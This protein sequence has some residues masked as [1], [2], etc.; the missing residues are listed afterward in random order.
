MVRAR[1]RQAIPDGQAGSER[2]AGG[3]QAVLIHAK[4]V[5]KVGVPRV[6]VDVDV[7]GELLAD[8]PGLVLLSLALGSWMIWFLL[9]TTSVPLGYQR[10]ADASG[11]GR[12]TVVWLSQGISGPRRAARERR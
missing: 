12:A 4:L 5:E 2:L 1:P 7:V 10:P 9:M 8:L 11:P 6:A 3:A